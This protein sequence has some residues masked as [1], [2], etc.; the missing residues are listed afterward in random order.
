LFVITTLINIISL[1]W[2]IKYFKRLK[3]LKNMLKDDVIFIEETK[4]E[5]KKIIIIVFVLIILAVI[6]IIGVKIMENILKKTL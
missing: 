6:G 3:E 2:T 1:R 4:S 5:T